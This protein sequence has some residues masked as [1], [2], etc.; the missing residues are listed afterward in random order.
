M[1]TFLGEVV[2]LSNTPSS[3]IKVR[4]PLIHGDLPYNKLPKA[5]IS[6]AAGLTP[7]LK[8]GTK[9]VVSFGDQN[10]SRPVILGVLVTDSG[11]QNCNQSA[12][13]TDIAVTHDVKLPTSI[14]V[15]PFKSGK[16]S[17]S[18]SGEDIASLRGMGAEKKQISKELGKMRDDIDDISGDLSEHSGDG[19]VHILNGVAK[20][21]SIQAIGNSLVVT[22]LPS[23]PVD[24][25]IVFLID[26]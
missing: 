19:D 23:A 6:T 26:D 11:N 12:E 21:S 5:T 20:I 16:E 1:S 17:Y 9:V 15:G 13:I 25:Q 8:N 14:S 22:S 4:V 18:I 2:T 7:S 10:V 24:G 3:D